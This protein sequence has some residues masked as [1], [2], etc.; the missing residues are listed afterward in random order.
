MD[1]V[2]KDESDEIAPALKG[3]IDSLRRV[4][5]GMNKVYEE[6]K[7]GDIEY[8]MHTDSFQGAY[9]EVADGYN[10]AIKMHVDNILKLLGDIVFI[11]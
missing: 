4:T 3:T 10:A 8:F 2:A 9:K 7:A 5:S 11:R 6:Q 1:I